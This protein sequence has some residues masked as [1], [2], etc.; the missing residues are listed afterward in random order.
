[1]VRRANLGDSSYN[2]ERRMRPEPN[3]LLR[4][5]APLS[6]PSENPGLIQ[7]PLQLRPGYTP[8]GKPAGTDHLA[9]FPPR[10]YAENP[11][12]EYSSGTLLDLALAAS[13]FEHIPTSPSHYQRTSYENAG[14]RQ[15]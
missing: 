3:R 15:W 7:I 6:V 5:E 2:S 9:K 10:T 8:D 11:K 12:L 1:M 4:E 14:L 13:C